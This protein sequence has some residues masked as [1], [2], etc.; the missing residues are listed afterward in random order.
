MIHQ[1]D[2]A[3][4]LAT[5]QSTENVTVLGC[6]FQRQLMARFGLAAPL[7]L[8]GSVRYNADGQSGWAHAESPY[9]YVSKHDILLAGKS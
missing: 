8:I 2:H 4:E 9:S 3:I 1:R 5:G 7:A 6:E